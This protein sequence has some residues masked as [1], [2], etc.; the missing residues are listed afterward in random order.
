MLHTAHSENDMNMTVGKCIKHSIIWNFEFNIC[1][2]HVSSESELSSY[3]H[4]INTDQPSRREHA[5]MQ[6]INAHFIRFLSCI[7]LDL[8]GLWN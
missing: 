4:L 8:Q 3:P 2:T 1:R 6:D 7:R 5:I